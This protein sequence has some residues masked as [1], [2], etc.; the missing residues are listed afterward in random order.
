[1]NTIAEHT[2]DTG[3]TIDGV[4]IKDG[5]VDGV[6]VSAVDSALTSHLGNSSNPHSVTKTQVGLGNV[7]NV[8]QTNAANIS[9]GIMDGDRLPAMST[10]KKGAV[11]ATGTPS[12]KYLKDDGTFATPAGGGDVTGPASTTENKVP[13]W[14]SATKTLK[15]G[16]TL[17]TSSLHTADDT[18]LASSKLV[19]TSLSAKAIAPATTTEN[20]LP[21]W[22]SAAKTLKDG[23]TLDTS[24][25]SP[26]LDTEVPT[27]KAVVDYVATIPKTAI[28]RLYDEMAGV[29]TRGTD[30]LKCY[31]A[32]TEI[33]YNNIGITLTGTDGSTDTEITFPAGNYI[34][35]TSL[36]YWPAAICYCATILFPTE[37]VCG[38]EGITTG[39][40]VRNVIAQGS[41]YF[42][43]ASSTSSKIYLLHEESTT[44]SS[45]IS[46]V[47][48][49]TKLP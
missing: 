22:D 28:I 8:D 20:K 34:V 27:S 17:D 35:S 3:V 5:F 12:G 21:Q 46:I 6:D 9:S 43:Y 40:P 44:G 31:S 11:P 33:L 23:L 24:I 26:G 25:S 48:Q 13:Q 37:Y 42:S 19:S 32:N 38:F 29:T 41:K 18:H 10:T 14:D 4:L 45:G 30:V 2:A 15:D 36:E 39:S 47:M 1:M 16:M 7:A 49:I